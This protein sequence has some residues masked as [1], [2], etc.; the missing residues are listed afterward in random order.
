MTSPIFL[1]R[2]RQGLKKEAKKVKGEEQEKEDKIIESID[3]IKGRVSRLS[4]GKK[5]EQSEMMTNKKDIAKIT[6]QLNELEGAAAKLTEVKE[7][8]TK[9]QK[10]LEKEKGKVDE[11]ELQ[12]GIEVD[13]EEV[14]DLEQKERRLKEELKVLEEKQSVLQEMDFLSK[15]I[16]TKENKMKKIMT[17]RNSEFIDLFG[18][19]PDGKRLRA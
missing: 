5:R 1:K 17:K 15:D 7:Q 6:R 10:E 13:R 8:W 16:E 4:E 19:V 3:E 2:K 9:G 12:S 14:R 18:A 11:K